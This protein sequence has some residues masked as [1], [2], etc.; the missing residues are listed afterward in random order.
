MDKKKKEIIVLSLVVLSVIIITVT[1]GL[2]IFNFSQAG[3]AENSVTTGTMTFL[4]SE[5][6]KIGNGI[7]MDEALPVEDEIGMA[8]TGNGK[9]F[10]F[11]IDS[12]TTF[13]DTEIPYIILHHI[14]SNKITIYNSECFLHIYLIVLCKFFKF[15]FILLNAF[16][17]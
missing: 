15:F 14:M 2:A 10:D 6:S 1:A 3:T 7:N 11:T 9:V 17:I 13:D 8:Q 12:T 4:Y 16:S 5:T